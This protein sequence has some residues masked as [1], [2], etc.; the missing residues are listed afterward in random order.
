MKFTSRKDFLFTS[1][2][3]GVIVL[4]VGL[5]F[6]L[7]YQGKDWFWAS[8]LV[9]AVIFLLLWIY[10]DTSY[11]LTKEHL[12]YKSGP[13]RG[14][15]NIADI[16]EVEA[17]KTLYVGI[18]PALARKGLI[19]KYNQYDEIYLSPNTNESFIKKLLELNVGIKIS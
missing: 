1:L 16:R 19:I 2:L 15:I 18:K 3:L 8:L 4:F 5:I 6:S 13:I 14:K 9:F 11:L 17:N 10:F 12:I 7:I